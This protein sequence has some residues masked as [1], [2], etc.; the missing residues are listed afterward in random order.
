MLIDKVLIKTRLQELAGNLNVKVTTNK[1]LRGSEIATHAVSARITDEGYA[2]NLNPSK[3]RG[4]SSLEKRVQFCAS[5][6]DSIG[7]I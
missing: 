6:I 5:C 1:H 4:D 2:F 7:G 3:I